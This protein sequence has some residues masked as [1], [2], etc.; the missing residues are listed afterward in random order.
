MTPPRGD[1]PDGDQAGATGHRFRHDALLYTSDSDYLAGTV[2]FVEAGLAAGEPV[3]VVLAPAKLDL[4]REAL[5]ADGDR[6][7]FADMTAMGRNPARII[8]AWAEFLA[9]AGGDGGPVRGI[10]EP[11][12]AS[13]TAAELAEAQLHEALLNRA[14]NG[15]PGFWLRCPYDVTTLPSDVVAEAYRSHP[16]VTVGPDE[17]PGESDDGTLEGSLSEPPSVAAELAFARGSLPHVRELVREH[18]E[19]AG[20]DP[21]S[22]RHLVLAVHEIAA[23]SVRHG[24]GQGVFRIWHDGRSLVCEV[25]DRGHLRDPMVGRVRPQA[26]ATGGRG[27]WMAN[28]LCD[29]VQVRS[30]A[31]GTIVR[32]HQA[33][34]R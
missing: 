3:L 34:R 10:G 27:V 5:G 13:R 11:V 14:F 28:Q 15:R 30:T 21:D 12:W 18:A 16:V 7:Q 6:V 4:V 22:T 24:G 1:I 29:L 17:H 9:D 32:L 20:F 23:N 26:N 2:P 31:A 8:P 25:R 19:R 33:A